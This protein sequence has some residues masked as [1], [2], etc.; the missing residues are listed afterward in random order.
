MRRE[1]HLEKKT[2]EFAN[3]LL[4]PAQKRI[5]TPVS[6]PDR[7]EARGGSLLAVP[8]IESKISGK[9]QLSQEAG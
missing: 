3:T 7:S 6:L 9:V 1:P 8:G 2:V 5:V 4:I